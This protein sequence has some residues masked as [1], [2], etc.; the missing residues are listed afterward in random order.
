MTFTISIPEWVFWLVGIPIGL[1]V[2]AL[3][4]AGFVLLRAISGGVYK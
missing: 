3:A 2:I 1:V 4:V